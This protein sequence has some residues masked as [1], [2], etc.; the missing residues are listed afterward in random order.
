MVS[1]VDVQRPERSVSA[2][3]ELYR[4]TMIPILDILFANTGT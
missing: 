4:L 3:A 2:I 1:G